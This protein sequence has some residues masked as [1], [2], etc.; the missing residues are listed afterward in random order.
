MPDSPERRG[1]PTGVIT[2]EDFF[3]RLKEPDASAVRSIVEAIGRLAD[4]YDS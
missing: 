1:W 2:A 4:E 3:L